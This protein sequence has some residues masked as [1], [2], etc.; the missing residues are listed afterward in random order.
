MPSFPGTFIRRGRH[1]STYRSPDEFRGKRVL[2]VGAGNSGCDIA[3]DAAQSARAAFISLRRGYHFIPKHVFGEPFDVFAERGRRWPVWLSQLLLGR[4]LRLLNG[5]LTR[6]GLQAPDH[7]VLEIASHRELANAALLS[8]GDLTAKPNVGVLNGS[9]S[10]F[11]DGSRERID[12]I[13][14]A[15]GYRWQLPYL[16]E[17]LVRWA[18]GRP[19]LYMGVFSREHPNLF[20]LGLMESNAAA[21][22]LFDELADLIARAFLAERDGGEDAIGSRR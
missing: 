9:R 14:C 21:Y 5:D 1:S 13:I 2:V 19:N 17:G 10:S 16:E 3:C 7:K 18:G 20:V 22:Q 8:H 6:F 11:S 15:T 4:L 12:L